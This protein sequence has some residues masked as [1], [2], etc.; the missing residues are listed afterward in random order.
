MYR[1]MILFLL[2]GISFGLFAQACDGNLGENIFEEGDFGSGANNILLPDPMIAPGYAYN[3]S[4]PPVDGLYVITNN[5]GA[6]SGLFTTW[7][8]I[9]DNSSDPNGYMMV[10]N[11][12]FEPGSFYEQQVD[13]LCENCDP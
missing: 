13:G 4:P 12:S 7:L 6:W 11:A 2:N 3:A 10:V 5:T 8:N 1:L 9:R